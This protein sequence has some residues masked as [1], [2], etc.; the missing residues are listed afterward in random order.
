MLR[1]LVHDLLHMLGLR[2]PAAHRRTSPPA[3][4]RKPRSGGA[5]SPSRVWPVSWQYA[6]EPVLTPSRIGW[7][8]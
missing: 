2:S 3:P 7:S 1:D 5:S 6:R 8:R 4:R